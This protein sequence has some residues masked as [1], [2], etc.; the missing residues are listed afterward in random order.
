MRSLPLTLLVAALASAT[1]ASAQVPA[2]PTPI[3]MVEIQNAPATFP[4]LAA[5]A[6]AEASFSVLLTLG[7]VVCAQQVTIPVTVTAT[8]SGA[9][10]FFSVAVDPPILNVTIAQG[11]HGSPPVG[12]AGTGVVDAVARATIT[13]NITANASVQVT[14][15]AAAPAPPGPPDGCQGAG[16]ISAATSAP[17][18]VFANMTAPPAPPTPTPTPEDTP[19]FGAAV[20][21][22]AVALVAYGRRRRH[23]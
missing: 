10:S 3:Y 14:L 9:P 8:A 13:G 23:E 6:S 17:V 2:P 18:V 4:A 5:N 11:P 1:L 16:Q 19:G 22:A 7:N 20:A 21:V 15:T 12:D